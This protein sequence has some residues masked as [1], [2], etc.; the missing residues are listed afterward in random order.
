MRE[1]K[2]Y[3]RKLSVKDERV[4]ERLERYATA[5]PTNEPLAITRSEAPEVALRVKS[6]GDRANRI[7]PSIDKVLTDVES[8]NLLFR[9]HEVKVL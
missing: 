9:D 3:D 2:T 4:V 6:L 8:G 1:I 7:F 5:L